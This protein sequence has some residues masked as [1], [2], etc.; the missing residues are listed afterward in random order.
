MQARS[1]AFLHTGAAP[2]LAG[3]KHIHV[4]QGECARIDL[5]HETAQHVYATSSE[6][7]TCCIMAAHCSR[8]GKAFIAHLDSST[9]RDTE[10]L[11]RGLQDMRHVRTLCR[12]ASHC[13]A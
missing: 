13:P 2:A 12:V 4:L 9:A 10:S 7:T 1:A 5:R 11:S 3:A 6:A 8:S